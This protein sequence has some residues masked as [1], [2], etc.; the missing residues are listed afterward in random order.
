MRN[1]LLNLL[2]RFELTVHK[3]NGNGNYPVPE[4]IRHELKFDSAL[5]RTNTQPASSEKNL[6]DET[7][8]KAQRYILNQQDK[9]D[10]HWV[11]ILEAD[12]TITSDYIMLMHFLQNVD[13]KKQKR[14]PKNSAF[15]MKEFLRD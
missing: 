15:W 8:N 9:S 12:T 10:G 7:I 13:Y 5:S 6:L 4:Q 11:G 14:I 1:F 3:F 2:D